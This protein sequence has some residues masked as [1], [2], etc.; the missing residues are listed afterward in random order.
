MKAQNKGSL[1]I[2]SYF[3]YWCFAHQCS[4][5]VQLKSKEWVLLSCDHGMGGPGLR[6]GQCDTLGHTT[7][8][9]NGHNFS[10]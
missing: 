2:S 4:T 8:M 6:P 9:C 1:D 3:I 7:I 5:R 10:I